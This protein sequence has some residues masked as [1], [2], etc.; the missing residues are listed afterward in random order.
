MDVQEYIR[1]EEFYLKAT[2]CVYRSFIKYYPFHK[3]K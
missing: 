3:Y 1:T 2:K